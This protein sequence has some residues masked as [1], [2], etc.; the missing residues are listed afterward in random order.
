[1]SAL[2][3]FGAAITLLNV[4]GHLFLGFEQ[5]WAQPLVALATTYSLEL[6]IE[7]ANA[8]AQRR[9]CVFAGGLDSL[10]TFLLPAHITGLATAMLLYANDRLLPIVFAASVAIAS[11][12]LLRVRTQSGSKHFLNPSNIGISLTLILFP[13]VGIAPPYMFTENL[14]GWADWALPALIV[15]SG[16]V[17]NAQLTHR[18]P[19]IGGWLGGFFLQAVVRSFWFGTPLA[20]ACLPMTGVPFVLF[21]FYMVTDPATTPWH[22]QRQVGF[23]LAVAAVYGVLVASHVVFGLFFSLAIVCAIRGLALAVGAL[24]S[25]RAQSATVI[26][27]SLLEDSRA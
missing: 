13:W 1:M 20:A 18:L 11:K 19:L 26:P 14:V 9:R 22:R 25:R 24:V 15:V 3:R 21:T 6:L 10:V 8:F 7:L 12:T 4:L 16:T 23:G 27:E 2:R 17:L 5:S